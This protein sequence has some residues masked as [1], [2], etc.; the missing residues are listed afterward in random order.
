MAAANRNLDCGMRTVNFVALSKRA[1]YDGRRFDRP[2][3]SVRRQPDA[4]VVHR[5]NGGTPLGR[6]DT[7]APDARGSPSTTAQMYQRVC[8]RYAFHWLQPG[9]YWQFKPPRALT[10]VKYRPLGSHSFSPDRGPLQPR[11]ACRSHGMF[12]FLISTDDEGLWSLWAARSAAPPKDQCETRSVRFA[13]VRLDPEA[14]LSI[15]DRVECS[16]SDDRE[17]APTSTPDHGWTA[18]HAYSF[19]P[20]RRSPLARKLSPVITI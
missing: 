1:S 16:R 20:S 19:L 18:V 4:L 13:W 7:L 8:H 15:I 10:R 14:V 5:A 12:F 2:G 9:R 17:V 6:G 11:R 3:R